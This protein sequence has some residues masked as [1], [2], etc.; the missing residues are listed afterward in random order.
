M[1]L[2]SEEILK[3]RREHKLTQQE[4]AD[5]IY[6]TRQ[7]VS[8]WECDKTFPSAD[9]VKKIK[10]EF[11]VDL[12]ELITE[13]K[14]KSSVLS[15][16]A[17]IK[18]LNKTNKL[19]IVG[20]LTIV[21]IAITTSIILLFGNFGK[22]VSNIQIEI[23]TKY[24]YVTWTELLNAEYYEIVI[25][26]R[27]VG[28]SESSGYQWQNYN[29]SGKNGTI[30]TLKIR[31]YEIVYDNKHPSVK[32]GKL[33]GS[34][35]EMNFIKSDPAIT[36]YIEIKDIFKNTYFTGGDSSEI[37]NFR[38]RL[39]GL[40][41]I[42]VYLND[43]NTPY[44]AKDVYIRYINSNSRGRILRNNNEYY[45]YVE[46]PSNIY[47]ED[48]DLMTKPEDYEMSVQIA[49]QPYKKFKIEL[50]QEK[51]NF[52]ENVISASSVLDTFKNAYDTEYLAMYS[53]FPVFSKNKL[54]IDC[55]SYEIT[56]T[57]DIR[58]KKISVFADDARIRHVS[59]VIFDEN[60]N[61]I[62]YAENDLSDYSQIGKCSMFIPFFHNYSGKIYIAINVWN[63]NPDDV[64]ITITIE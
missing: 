9:V 61:I 1:K 15:N 52:S 33:I 17:V 40:F 62:A 16:N 41:K 24:N 20:V 57:L 54:P 30:H 48:G 50:V 53:Y 18:K 34:S 2:L 28:K 5:R 8:K 19:L 45:F 25:D 14:I 39:F 37:I 63:N 42:N 56:T 3:I 27:V 23:D 31:A 58:G 44:N 4:F 11:G 6:V 51:M 26:D 21:V 32:Y 59:F 38:T 49:Y 64:D 12:N 60:E 22:Q 43:S 29:V 35:N 13:E 10:E 55:V 47:D 7:A 36:E 46:V